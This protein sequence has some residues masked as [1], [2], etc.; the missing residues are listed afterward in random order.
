M[1]LITVS[2]A[3]ALEW[4]VSANSRCSR[5]AHKWDIRFSDKVRHRPWNDASSRAPACRLARRHAR[6][7][8]PSRRTAGDRVQRPRHYCTGHRAAATRRVVRQLAAQVAAFDGGNSSCSVR[9]SRSPF[10]VHRHRGARGQS[11]CNE[12]REQ[13]FTLPQRLQNR[14]RIRSSPTKRM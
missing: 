1:S 7:A 12:C 6:T 4:M 2:K 11:D 14:S 5:A 3:S 13:G 8:G 10:G 9:L